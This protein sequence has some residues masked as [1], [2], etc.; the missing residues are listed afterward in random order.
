MQAKRRPILLT[1]MSCL[2]IICLVAPGW[3]Q[4]VTASITGKVTDPTG[5]AV[6]GAKATAT[7]VERGTQ[8][9]AT[10]N[11]EGFYNLSNLPV[12]TYNLRVENAGFQTA[13][14]SNIV[15]Q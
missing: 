1:L 15:L 9:T 13:T 6:P 3:A 11:S 14:Q 5:A 4:Q 12:G 2:L 7:S 8:Y 10:T